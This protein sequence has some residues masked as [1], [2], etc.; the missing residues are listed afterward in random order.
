MNTTNFPTFVAAGEALT[1]M[2]RVDDTHWVSK[3]GG[4]TWNVARVMASLGQDSAQGS[5]FA[6]SISRDCFGQDLQRASAEA[7]LDLR[8]LQQLDY[9][10]LLAIVHSANPPQYFFVGDNAADLHFN[11][12]Q[13]PSG[14]MKAVQWVHF[15]GISLARQPLAG[16]LIALARELKTHGVKISY[17]PNFR[18][19]MDQS[20]DATLRTMSELADVIKVSDEDLAGL[21]RTNDLDA[22]FDTLRSFNPAAS[23]LYTRGADGASFYHHDDIA[24][25]AAIKVNVVDSVG[26]GDAAMG[27]LIYSLLNMP[28]RSTAE[29]LHF[30]IASGAAAC[31]Y[32]GAT[33]PTLTMVNLLYEAH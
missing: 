10:P 6:G 21:F 17:D 20:Y 16:K 28:E 9:S 14:W 29:H 1:D 26:A 7:G 22:A 23:I 19:L 25:E 32:A 3:V 4:S 18:V 5:A 13:L 2:I 11:P 33:P 30:A 24:N 31:Q 27:G 15:G 8:F 12:A